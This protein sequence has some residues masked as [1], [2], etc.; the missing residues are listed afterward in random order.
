MNQERINHLLGVLARVVR[1]NR[2]TELHGE[3][4]LG[5][6]MRAGAFHALPDGGMDRFIAELASLIDDQKFEEDP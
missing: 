5:V 3:D 1:K 2:L 6:L 4:T